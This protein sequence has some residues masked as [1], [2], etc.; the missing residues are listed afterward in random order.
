ME[1]SQ[2][3]RQVL[4]IVS[5]YSGPMVLRFR[6][7]LFLDPFLNTK[8]DTELSSQLCQHLSATVTASEA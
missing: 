3:E 8:V 6:E 5:G 2:I 1:V 4:I 7:V